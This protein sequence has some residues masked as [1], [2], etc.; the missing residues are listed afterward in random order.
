MYLLDTD[1]I[2]FGLKGHAAVKKNLQ[3]HLNDPMKVSVITLME[4][5]YGAYK[6]QKVESNLAKVKRIESTLEVVTLATESAEIFGIYKSN[7][8]KEGTPLDDFDLILASCALA[9]NLTL[10]TNNTK[11][12]G[13]IEG[14][15][16]TN[17]TVYPE[18]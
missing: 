17:W 2:I 10:V 9:H 1:T 3:D 5:Y 13:R 12:F 14:L 18:S 16:V 7:L 15:K 4:L 8:E 11:H 6:S